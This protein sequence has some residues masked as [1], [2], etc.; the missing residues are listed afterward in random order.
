MHLCVEQVE[1][2][3]TTMKTADTTTKFFAKF[4]V[5]WPILWMVF[6][7][8]VVA[9]GQAYGVANAVVRHTTSQPQGVV[10]EIQIVAVAEH[11]DE[12]RYSK[13]ELVQ[14][15][16]LKVIADSIVQRD[17]DSPFKIRVENWTNGF[18]PPADFPSPTRM[19]FSAHAAEN[20][21]VFSGGYNMTLASQ[22]QFEFAFAV[23]C[24][25]KIF[26]V[27]LQRVKID[28]LGIMRAYLE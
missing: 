13:N 14:A 21:H 19:C 10:T 8:A 27:Q 4:A 20:T 26:A 7:V 28:S 18:V 23:P 3:D 22:I 12:H 6:A 5:L 16:R 25:Y 1:E 11:D 2:G 24:R 9:A 15:T 17:L